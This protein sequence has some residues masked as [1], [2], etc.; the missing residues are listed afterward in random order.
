MKIKSV[1]SVGRR[2][3]YDLSVADVEHYTLANGVVTH[4]TGI[5]YS[6]DTA[7]IMGRRQEKEGTE[8]V[9]YT[10]VMNIEKS[11]YVKEKSKIPLTVTYDG[12]INTFSG[13]LEI[14]LEIG[15]VTKPSNG[16]YSRAISFDAETGVIEYEEKKVRAK[17]TETVEWW[18]PLFS[19]K[20]FDDAIKRKYKLGE[21]SVSD[22]VDTVSEDLY[23]DVD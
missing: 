5:L 19:M 10:F 7:I 2:K 16:W 20:E 21:M 14:A 17:E 6:C 11:R 9:G 13:L 4:N 1:K 18:K 22:T 3:V 12:G 15:F 8:I 23:N